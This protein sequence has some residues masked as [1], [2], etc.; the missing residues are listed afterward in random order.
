MRF[1]VLVALFIASAAHAQE[2]KFAL[3]PYLWLPNVNGTLKY[4]P[5]PSGTGAPDVDTG[6]NKIERK[7]RERR[8]DD[9]AIGR[10]R[11]T[12]RRRHRVVAFENGY[13]GNSNAEDGAFDYTVQDI[14]AKIHSR[15]HLRPK[16]PGVDAKQADTDDMAA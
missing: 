3:T 15:L 6:P 2:W 12:L 16:G 14:V 9:R 4:N 11:N 5:P 8:I 1:L 7:D 10:A 13:P